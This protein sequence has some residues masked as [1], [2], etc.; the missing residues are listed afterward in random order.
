MLGGGMRQAGIIAA[1]AKIAVTDNVNKL[2][3]DHD[4]AKYLAQQLNS[5]KGFQVDINNIMTNIVFAKTEDSIDTTILAEQLKTKGIL[6]SANNP[7]RLV[8]HL[9]IT[10]QDIDTFIG[11]IQ[12]CAAP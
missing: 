6:I 4:N 7:I 3:T 1:A 12:E 11:A 5:V 8:T 10:K 9:N 2:A